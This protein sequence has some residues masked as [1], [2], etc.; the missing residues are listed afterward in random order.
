MYAECVQYF[1]Q[2]GKERIGT[3]AQ[4]FVETFATQACLTRQ[5]RHTASPRNVANGGKQFFVIALCQ[6][7]CQVFSDGY[8]VVQKLGDIE[9]T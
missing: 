2:R 9:R 3:R 4:C 1:H 5:L 6:H 8:I 7:L